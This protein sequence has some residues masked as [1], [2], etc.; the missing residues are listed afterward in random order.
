M[1]IGDGAIYH[2][3]EAKPTI[4]CYIS[5]DYGDQVTRP[6][7]DVIAEVAVYDQVYPGVC[8][9]I[10]FDE[11]ASSDMTDVSGTLTETGQLYFDYNA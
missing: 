11:A 8:D 10:F 2:P 3:E 1:G 4:I 6:K 7:V 5:T 9:G